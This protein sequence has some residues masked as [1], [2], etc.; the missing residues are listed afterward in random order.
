LL[1][2]GAYWPDSQSSIIPDT[3]ADGI[4][5]YNNTAQS[6]GALSFSGNYAL[7]YFAFPYECIAPN[8]TSHTPRATILNNVLEWLAGF[9]PPSLP[10]D[11]S[12]PDTSAENDAHIQIPIYADALVAE[13][14][15]SSFHFSL[16]WTSSVV[17]LDSPFASLVGTIT[18]SDWE[19]VV[20]NSSPGVVEATVSATSG[21]FLVGEGA[22]IYLNFH[23]IGIA[24]DYTDLSFVEFTFTPERLVTTDNGS[25]TVLAT[26]VCG[27]RDMV[28]PTQFAI[29]SISPN[30]FN[31]ETAINL[32]LPQAG[33]VDVNVYNLLGEKTATIYSGWMNKGYHTLNFNAID[34]ASGIYLLQVVSSQGTI[35]SKLVLMK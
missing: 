16:N 31:P 25:L 8:P 27:G 7:V 15:I 24:N 26:G 34:L 13:D 17:E 33:W 2:G 22:I 20:N 3:L 12:M 14:S 28:T 21:T 9:E 1:I 30:P 6:I 19:A 18:P 23:V 5:R 11:I 10:V 4:Y 29:T 35:V 32:A